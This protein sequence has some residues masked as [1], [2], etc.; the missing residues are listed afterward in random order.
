MIERPAKKEGPKCPMPESSESLRILSRMECKQETMIEVM[1]SMDDRLH[2][3]T[4][5]MAAVAA[6]VSM[7][8]GYLLKDLSWL[9]SL[10]GG[11]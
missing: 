3:M 7:C 9:T 8:V 2:R 4:I 10:I 5:K 6:V 1:R 11:L